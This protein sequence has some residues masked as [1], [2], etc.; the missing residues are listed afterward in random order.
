MERGCA[1]NSQSLWQTAMTG[2]CLQAAGISNVSG[3]QN[4][5]LVVKGFSR[6]GSSKVA[7]RPLV[8]ISSPTL[9]RFSQVMF[10]GSKDSSADAATKS[11][12]IYVHYE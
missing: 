11:E 6:L 2:M 8:R 1:G 3:V 12:G 10:H 4:S 9:I 7:I 5:R